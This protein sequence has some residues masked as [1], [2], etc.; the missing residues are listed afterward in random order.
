MLTSGSIR[1]VAASAVLILAACGARGVDV[2]T[3][4]PPPPT[5]ADFYG[6]YELIL[7]GVE[8]APAGSEMIA[9][10]NEAGMT[11][12]QM[13]N[14]MLRTQL[15]LGTSP[16]TIVIWDEDESDPVCA[17]EGLYAYDDDDQMITLTLISDACDGRSRSA[18][19]A[20]LIRLD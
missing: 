20:R 1:G 17:A 5:T 3:Q 13:G 2:S 10:W 9:T 19:G 15:A 6:M 4:S 11:V 12:T 8:A 7:P 16:G 14:E 18:D